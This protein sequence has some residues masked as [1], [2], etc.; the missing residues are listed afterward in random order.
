[1]KSFN[2][3]YNVQKRLEFIGKVLT[4]LKIISKNNDVHF[5]IYESVENVDPNRK[6]I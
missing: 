2:I 5:Y 4:Y 1:M 6:K 3:I